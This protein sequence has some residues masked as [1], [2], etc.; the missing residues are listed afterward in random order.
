MRSAAAAATPGGAADEEA[1][2]ARE[3]PARLEGLVVR[4]S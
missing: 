1:F 3:R 4:R 2:L